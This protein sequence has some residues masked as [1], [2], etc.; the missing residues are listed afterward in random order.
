M[1]TLSDTVRRGV[2]AEFMRHPTGVI[3]ATKPQL[4]AC[5]DAA[6]EWVDSVAAAFAAALPEPVRGNGPSH[7]LLANSAAIAAEVEI[8]D[9][10]AGIASREQSGVLLTAY[11]TASTWLTANAAEYFTALGANGVPLTQS[12]AFRVLEAVCRRRAV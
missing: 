9:V 5:V 6:D 10:A 2:W 7:T 11:N 1:A 8:A 3:A 4:R 12:Q